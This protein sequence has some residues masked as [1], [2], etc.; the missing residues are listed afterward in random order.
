MSN[1]DKIQARRAIEALRSGVPNRDAVRHL[2]V[3]QGEVTQKF[4]DLLRDMRESATTGAASRNSLVVSGGFGAGKS[5]ILEYLR[6]EAFEHHCV[7]SHVVVS[8]ETALSNPLKLLRSAAETAVVSDKT[9][10]AVPEILFTL[11][12]NTEEFAELFKWVHEDASFESRL[13][14]IVKVFEERPI[15]SD[16]L[17]DKIAMEWSGYPMR[18]VELRA[19]LKEIGQDKNYRVKA[20]RQQELAGQLWRFL[21]RLFRAAGYGGWIVLIDEVELILRYTRLQ[22][23]KSYAQVARLAGMMKDFQVCGLLPVFAV[24]AEFWEHADGKLNDSEEIPAWLRSRGRPGDEELARAAET[25]MKLLKKS[26]RLRRA[27]ADELDDLQERVRRLHCVAFG[28]EAP[29]LADCRRGA[30]SSVREHLKSWI[31]Q[32]DLILLNPDYRPEVVVD[33]V[34]QD[35]SEDDDLAREEEPLDSE[36]Q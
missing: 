30:S 7:C 10:R 11:K 20:I 9:G 1:G 8:K 4:A 15:G 32:W 13:A 6:H 36:L 24:A 28:W 5:H 17:L 16:E 25:G 14:P 3:F 12:T 21:P 33:E 18:T 31:T 19:S 34:V 26:M 29:H 35:Y 2:G 22:R 23:A 27:Q